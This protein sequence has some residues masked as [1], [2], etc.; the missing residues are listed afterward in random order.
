MTVH[1]R[2]GNDFDLAQVGALHYRSRAHA[3]AGFLSA[4]ALN[5]GSPAA[6]GEWW[7]ERRRWEQ[8]THRL[9]VA[10]TDDDTVVGFTYLGVSEVPGATELYAIHVDP[11]HVGTGVGKA[12][13]VDA[14]AHLGDRAV[15]WVLEG[16]DRARRFYERGGWAADGTTREAPMGGEV[17][18]QLRYALLSGRPVKPGD[19]SA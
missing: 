14:L 10:V 15:L 6:L 7:T 18:L 5:F 13:M 16:N 12:L 9:T 3:Y 4:E 8:D 17:T 1:L 19:G 11:E 2:T